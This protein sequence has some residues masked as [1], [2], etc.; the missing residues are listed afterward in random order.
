MPEGAF[1][2]YRDQAW[3]TL[4]DWVRHAQRNP[5]T[6]PDAIVALMASL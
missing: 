6:V 4:Y 3:D 5:G 1:V 2:L